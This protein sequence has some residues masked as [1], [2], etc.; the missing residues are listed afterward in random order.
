[1]KT[2]QRFDALLDIALDLTASL[3]STARYQRLIAGLRQVVPCDAAVLLRYQQGELVPVAAEGLA[4]E[5]MGCRFSPSDHPRLDAIL[6]S[7]TPILFPSDDKRPDPYDG[8]VDFDETKRLHVHSCMGKSLYVGDTLVGALT[9][10]AIKLGAFDDV[11]EQDFVAFAALAAATMRTAQLIEA[12]EQLADHRGQVAEALVGEAM[13]RGG[14]LIGDSDPMNNLK[15][16]IETVAQSDLTVLISG[17][18]GVG[19]E[20]V[21]R[22]VHS[23]SSRNQQ[24]LVHVNCAALPESIAEK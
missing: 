14:Q 13:E 9:V 7:R 11:D 22:T 17:E 21:A 19:K 4:P 12:L 15:R 10:D 8:L 6:N 18:T 2:A 1:M 23:L 20:I 3:S 5:V 24:P 16:E